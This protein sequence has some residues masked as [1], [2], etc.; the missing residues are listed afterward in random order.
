MDESASNGRRWQA[1]VP[2]PA[3]TTLLGDPAMPTRPPR[4]Q[5]IE[6]AALLRAFSRAN[7]ALLQARTALDEAGD[8]VVDRFHRAQ[9][10]IDWITRYVYRDK[11]A[12]A[13]RAEDDVVRRHADDGP[14]D[15]RRR[16][17]PKWTIWVVLI[18]A[19]IFD[20]AFVGN[21][22]QRIFGAGPDELIYYLSYLPGIGLALGLFVA[23]QRLA[24][25]LFRHRER[26]T[27]SGRRG[28]LN[29]RLLLRKVLWDW[30]PEEET[31][32]DRDLPWDRL[33]GPVVFAGLI[34]G[35]LGAGAYIRAAQAKSFQAL[36]DFQPVFV[37]LLVLLSV[38][39]LAVKALTHNP[40]AD[41]ALDARKGMDRVRKSVNELTEDA[42]KPLVEH[43][44]A[45]NALRSAIL[46][47][48]GEA[49]RIVE[50]ECARILD[51][52]GRRGEDGPLRLPLTVLQRAGEDGK[53]T[54]QPVLPTL[55]V[56]ILQD[57]RDVAERH[58]PR[59]LRSA[60][61]SAGAALNRQFRTGDRD[62]PR[63]GEIPAPR[64]SADVGEEG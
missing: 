4:V 14:E 58:H 43:N 1:P 46:S 51:D 55:R 54:E 26:A 48:E 44:K 32:E 60:F 7:A 64:R 3:A 62:A 35:M 20:V 63:I 25:N 16:A 27:R 38:S 18:V 31:R 9:H 5:D 40:H 37:G 41:K 34:V 29:P 15:R 42:R 52:R 59:I 47:V 2:C 22:V 36:A 8:L 49:V 56:D 17:L 50:E 57:A 21:V 53:T 24:E 30:R 45:W 6:A 10:A 19:G 12:E 13:R 11:A 23:S 33:A 28:R 61:A 39:A